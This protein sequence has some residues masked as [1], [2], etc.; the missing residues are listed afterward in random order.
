V[1]PLESTWNYTATAHNSQILLTIQEWQ[2]PGCTH[3]PAAYSEHG[4]LL[5]QVQHPSCESDV[6]VDKPPGK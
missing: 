6:A 5:L 2:L 4:I 1:Q 3:T